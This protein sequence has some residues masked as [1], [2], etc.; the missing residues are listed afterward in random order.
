[1]AKVLLFNLQK[2]PVYSK[3]K[4]KI[5]TLRIPLTSF[6]LTSIFQ[7]VRPNTHLIG[8]LPDAL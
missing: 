5:L 3:N 6:K 4:S 1:M 8:R 2:K 7:H